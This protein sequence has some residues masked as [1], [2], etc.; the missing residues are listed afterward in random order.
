MPLEYPELSARMIGHEIVIFAVSHSMVPTLDLLA[1]DARMNCDLLVVVVDEEEDFEQV[2]PG[3]G[4]HHQYQPVWLCCLF[5][6]FCD[7]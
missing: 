4:V 6:C 5:N 2:E 3:D 7:C 1:L